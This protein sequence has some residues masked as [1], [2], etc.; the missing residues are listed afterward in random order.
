MNMTDFWIFNASIIRAVIF[1]TMDALSTF[2]TLT[3]L[4]ETARHNIP[5][6]SHFHTRC[7]GN[8][9]SQIILYLPENK[10]NLNFLSKF[11]T[12]KTLKKEDMSQLLFSFCYTLLSPNA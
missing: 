12:R 1:L 11:R 2:E 7:C 3:D 9:K 8:Q 10:F 4:Y 6:Y 5:E